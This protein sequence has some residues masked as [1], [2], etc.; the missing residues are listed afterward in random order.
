[1]ETLVQAREQEPTAPRALNPRLD[2]DLEVICLKCLEKE[3]SQRYGSAEA[4]AQDSPPR[5]ERLFVERV[6]DALELRPGEV[7][8]ERELRE[9]GDDAVSV[10]PR[11]A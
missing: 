5:L 10:H 11:G 4:L 8:E 6:R 7:R 9:L 1:M 3:P 2:R